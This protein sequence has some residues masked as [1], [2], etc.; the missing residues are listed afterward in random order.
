MAEGNKSK[1]FTFTS[2]EKARGGLPDTCIFGGRINR[3]SASKQPLENLAATKLKIYRNPRNGFH[4]LIAEWG[5]AWDF[6]RP[7]EL[8]WV[9]MSPS[10]QPIERRAAKSRGWRKQNACPRHHLRRLARAKIAVRAC[11]RVAARKFAPP[12]PYKAARTLRD[13]LRDAL[14]V[15]GWRAQRPEN[16]RL[17]P[18]GG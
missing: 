4:Y 17:R 9:F 6:S 15:S 2:E 3:P 16:F 5:R 10:N 8:S 18:S 7:G 1:K 11:V 13:S 12:S 14:L